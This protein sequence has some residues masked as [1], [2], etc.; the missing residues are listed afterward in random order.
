MAKRL[1]PG[2]DLDYLDSASWNEFAE[3]SDYVKGLQHPVAKGEPVKLARGNVVAAVKLDDA[4]PSY[5]VLA[6]TRSG[7][8]EPTQVQLGEPPAFETADPSEG[9]TFVITQ[10][11]GATG[12]LVSATIQGITWAKVDIQDEADDTA[13][14][15]DGETAH[16]ISGTDKPAKILWKESGTGVKWA[17]ILIGGGAP[18]APSSVAT[19]F[20]MV[21]QDIPAMQSAFDY[22][23]ILT[24]PPTGSMTQ[25]EGMGWLMKPLG[26]HYL[27]ADAD[28]D[29]KKWECVS[30]S[31][32]DLTAYEEGPHIWLHNATGGILRAKKIVQWV[33]R[34]DYRVVHAEDCS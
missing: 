18:A 11:H 2:Q 14:I 21:A 19:G 30:A 22:D 6:I 23:D 20:A 13:G 27:E 5:S 4:H 12:Q 3:T 32:D 1:T 16:L 15:D 31:G 34:G 26:N 8:D 29:W 7:S 28:T 17:V 10:Q 9:D 24:A 25:G 33:R